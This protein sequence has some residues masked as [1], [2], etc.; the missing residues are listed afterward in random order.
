MKI[1]KTFENIGRAVVGAV[2]KVLE[3]MAKC[4]AWVKGKVGS[5][6]Q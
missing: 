2:W 6:E 1:F 4:V 3:T 5:Y